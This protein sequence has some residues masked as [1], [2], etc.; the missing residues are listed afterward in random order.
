MKVRLYG[1][2]VCLLVCASG[3]ILLGQ[4]ATGNITGDVT[5]TSGAVIPGTNVTASNPATGQVF[6]TVTDS[7]GIFRFYYLVP[8][9][10]NLSFQHTGFKTL[11][12]PGIIVQANETPAV[13]VQLAVGSSVQKIEV[14]AASPLLETATSTTGTIMAGKEMNTLPIM[15]RYVWMTMYLMP[16]VTSMD[17]FS[18]D[19]MRPRGLGL[20]LDGM[21]GLEP[22]VRGESTNGTMSTDPDAIQEV[23]LVTTVLPAEYG[24][25]AGGMLSET[26]K[27][28]TNAFHFE[29]QDRYVNNAML[30]RAYFNLTGNAPFSYH[31]LSSLVS[32][33]VIIPK[34]YNGR[35]KTFFLFGWSMHRERYDESVFT[36]VPSEA[37]LNGDFSFGGLG[38]PIYNPATVRQVNGQWTATPYPGNI[39]PTSQFDPAV[40]KFLNHN[41]WDAAN[42][43][44]DATIMTATGPENN[45]G[46]IS[47]YHSYRYRYDAKLNQNFSNRNQ[48]WVAYHK[49]VNQV[50]S[51]PIG[52]NWN[53]ID[54]GAVP[55]PSNQANAQ[56]DDTYIFG[57]RLVND[58][59]IGFD[60]YIQSYTPPGLNQGWAQQLGIPGVSGATFPEFLSSTGT[61]F[62]D[63]TPVGGASYSAEQNVTVR[64]NVTLQRGA[65]SLRFGF[66]LIKTAAN[67]L[68]ASTPGGEFEF[69]DTGYPF[70]PDTGNDF[71]GFL[72]GSVTQATFNTT[73]ATWL[74]RWWT[75]ALYAQ[76][77]WMVNQRLTLNLGLRWDMETP[78]DTK[79]GQESEFDPTATDPL[80]GLPG[81]IEHPTGPLA[82]DNYTHFQPRLGA[83]YHLS[84]NVVFRAGFGV[85]SIPLFTTALNQDFDEYQSEET[86]E[87]PVGVPAPKFYLSQGPGPITY[88]I[89]PNGTSPFVGTN[90]STRT[91]TYYEPNLTN[92]YSMNWNATLQ[93]EF[94]PNWL[95]SLSYQGSEGNGLLEGWNMNT[96]PLNVSTNPAT[97]ENIYQNYQNYV[98]YPNFGD[99]T[100]WG[101]FGHSTFHSGTVEL[102]KRLI[103]H[104]TLTAF[105]TYSHAIDDCDNDGVC[106]GET[107]YDRALEKGTA[108]YNLFNRFVAS[109]TYMLPVGQGRAFM[110]RG[111]ILND[112]FGGWNLTWIQT[113]QSGVP[114]TFTMAGSPY[115]YL[116]GNDAAS[117]TAPRP[118]QILPNGQVNVPNWTI[119]QRF[120]TSLENPM[121]N[122]KAFSYPA[123]FTVGNVGR[124]T[125]DGPA[126]VWSQSS[127][128][129]DVNIRD[130]ATLQIRYDI[131][132]IFKNPNFENPTSVVNIGSPGLFGKPTATT[133]GWCCLG[134]QFV[135][136]LGIRLVY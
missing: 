73:L 41:P 26:Y 45:F 7:R 114:V 46:S 83:A 59:S 52:F 43:Q 104:L 24:G 38:Y 19:G 122:I 20:T 106:T 77:D 82:S 135:A 8:A 39:I 48:M 89:L 95:L 63:A 80:T 79:Y 14:S 61:P 16:G 93:Y 6:R 31:E 94:H 131:N 5:D 109:A 53:L 105:Y 49:V 67:S 56:I 65:H 57:P 120:D 2:L 123:A 117:T 88:N 110:N 76:D 108:G 60:R 51:D 119:G 35:N 13:D 132:N 44:A 21:S 23:K 81:A 55:T 15:Q 85:N 70:T 62:F 29:S 97:L 12:R 18:I 9:T 33:P 91:A 101:N 78:F 92:A 71:A 75:P 36:S 103:Q 133:G 74:P 111:G 69:G 22:V 90:Y 72:L 134:G 87:S 115:N 107:F 129:K 68:E 96:V 17:G 30:H 58:A 126:L 1:L 113:F 127:L 32:G 125:I 130:K 116:P 124:N 121:W 136:T 99:I 86:V 112:V 84:K 100:E 128:E 3:P 27:S 54:G 4:S 64:D 37:E 118:D 102:Q 25:S 66:Q 28:G 42:N 50:V 11:A 98:P 10:Y 34:I 47:L 40:V